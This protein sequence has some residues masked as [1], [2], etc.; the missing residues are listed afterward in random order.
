[1]SALYCPFSH[2]DIF[3]ELRKDRKEM[4]A[5]TI[6]T[7]AHDLNSRDLPVTAIVL[8]VQDVHGRLEHKGR[9][10]QGRPDQGT[11]ATRRV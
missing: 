7:A 9:P 3:E 4:E 5:T 8:L 2:Q 6:A 11:R 1:M 10:D